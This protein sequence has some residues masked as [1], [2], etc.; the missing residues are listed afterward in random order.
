MAVQR[1][2]W[3]DTGLIV[4]DFSRIKKTRDGKE[5]GGII[6]EWLLLGVAPPRFGAVAPM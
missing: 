3:G 6:K 5:M 2:C 4:A 1:I